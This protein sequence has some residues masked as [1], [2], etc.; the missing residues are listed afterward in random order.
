MEKQVVPQE[1]GK[2]PSVSQMTD[3][4]RIGI[5]KEIFAT[6]TGGY[7][8]LN[9]LLS[10]RRDVAWRR[11]T[12][13]KMRFFSSNRLLDVA[14]GTADLA[15]DTARRRPSVTITG[16]DFAGEMLRSGQ[17]KI[18]AKRLSD[19]VVLAQGDALCLPF[20]DNTFD[21]SS[22]AFGIRNIPD[23]PTALREMLRVV[24][25]GGQVLVLEMTFIRNWFTTLLY[26]TYLNRILPVI[27]KLFSL[28][29]RAYYYLADSIMNFPSPAQFVTLMEEVGMAGIKKHKLTF[30]LTYLY[31][32][33][34]PLEEK[35]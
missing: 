30:G 25:P 15:I 23:R 26:R 20:A 22:I 33:T 28:N 17:A 6:V 13:K 29:P 21:A 12:V 11:F 14:T 1:E 24:V 35:R 9:H 31:V 10:L 16:L 18:A 3:E 5:V 8:F 19:R 32:G 34:K 2:Y 4:Q 27:A 7:D